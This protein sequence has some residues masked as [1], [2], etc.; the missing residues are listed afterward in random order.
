[1]RERPDPD[2]DGEAFRARSAVYLEESP[3]IG[4]DEAAALRPIEP[5]NRQDDQGQGETYE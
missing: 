1:M 5:L 4:V 2:V 3:E